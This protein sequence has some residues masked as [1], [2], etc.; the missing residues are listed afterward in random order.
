VARV[1]RELRDDATAAAADGAATRLR[2]AQTLY[3]VAMDGI[4]ERL[5]PGTAT[6]TADAD[7]P[8]EVRLEWPT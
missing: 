4:R 1:L 3:R 8:R 5:M 7:G 6:L 2:A